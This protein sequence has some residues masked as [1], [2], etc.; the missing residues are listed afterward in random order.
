MEPPSPSYAAT[1]AHRL[2]TFM[3]V[4]AIAVG[5]LATVDAVR[6]GPRNITFYAS[7]PLDYKLLPKG[8]YAN[9]EQRTGMVIKHPTAREKR[10]ALAANLVPLALALPLLWLL[11]GIARSVRDGDPFGPQNVR[12]LRAIGVLLIVGSVA[13]GYALGALQSALADPYTRSPFSSV[14]TPGLLPAD[15][16][17]PWIPLLC[18]LGAFV[19]AQVFAHGVRLREDVEATI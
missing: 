11:R 17:L 8:V 4:A 12:R 9:S 3:L 2:T 16:D 19:L 13:V 14:R 6:G 5:V 7:A 15:S 10:L 18:G 1:V